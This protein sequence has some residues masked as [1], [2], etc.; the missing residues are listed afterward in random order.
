MP[1]AFGRFVVAPLMPA[2][3]AAYPQV[4]VE[5]FISDRDVDPLAEGWTSPCG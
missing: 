2:F 4:D 3:L 5:L 1:K